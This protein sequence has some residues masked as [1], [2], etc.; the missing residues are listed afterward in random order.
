MVLKRDKCSR[1]I[2]WTRRTL[3]RDTL[4]TLAIFTQVKPI[5]LLRGPVDLRPGRQ[6]INIP[7]GVLEDL[8]IFEYLWR[9]VYRWST[10]A[11]ILKRLIGEI[12]N[13]GWPCDT[14]SKM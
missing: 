9:N 6:S 14:V 2:K 11:P 7:P 4:K 5:P 1:S 3:Q 8:K 12:S 10:W 13:T